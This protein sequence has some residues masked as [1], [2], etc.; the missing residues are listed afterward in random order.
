[1]ETNKRP[2][3]QP[4]CFSS[5]IYISRFQ[6]I[7]CRELLNAQLLIPIPLYIRRD[8]I[9]IINNIS[10]LT[11]PINKLNVHKAISKSY[12]TQKI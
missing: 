11:I 5:R 6:Y 1:M 2:N 7:Y 3:V 10:I 12:D 4:F 8:A 9:N